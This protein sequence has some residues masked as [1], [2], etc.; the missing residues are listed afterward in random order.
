MRKISFS[1]FISEW[2]PVPLRWCYCMLCLLLY[3]PK[4]YVQKPLW[5]KKL[6]FVCTCIYQSRMESENP[7]F[8]PPI[9]PGISIT[10]V[11]ED[12]EIF[13]V[14]LFGSFPPSHV[15]WYSD[16]GTL[17]LP[18]HNPVSGFRLYINI[19]FILFKSSIFAKY[20]KVITVWYSVHLFC[21]YRCWRACFFC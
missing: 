5:K 9:A 18:S 8:P 12:A 16:N 13:A 20:T 11:M 4:L 10:T 2:Q 21:I 15:R 17:P 6:H 1:L 7:P 14:V 3:S 19:A